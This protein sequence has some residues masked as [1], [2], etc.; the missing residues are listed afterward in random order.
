VDEIV[1]LLTEEQYRGKLVVIFAGYSGQ[2]SELLNKVNPGLKSRVADVIDFPDFT[3]AAAAELAALQLSDKRLQLPDGEDSGY[4]EPWMLQ[5]AAAPLWANGRDVETFVRRV[6]V[7]CATRDT[8]TATTDV[9]DAALQV[10]LQIKGGSSGDPAPVT[11]AHPP[12]ESESPFMTADPLLQAP[13]SFDILKNVQLATL[14]GDDDDDA[15]TD[16]STDF[17]EAL[18]EAVVFLGFDQSDAT[19]E[20]LADMLVAALE[21]GGSFPDIIR[22]RVASKTGAAHEAVDAALRRLARPLLNAVSATVK[23]NTERREQLDE[24]EDEDREEEEGKE[25]K[26]MERLR[27]MGPCPAGFAWFRQGNGWRC[28]GGSHFVYDDDPILK[29]D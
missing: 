13:P 21:P 22:S 16:D 2:M 9:L 17:A 18:E 6:T 5:L 12:P 11:G 15:D 26:I 25:A 4:L 29:F 19:R 28:G 3:P 24:L 23:Y 27:T 7:E 20:K 8:T 10:V 14:D 1:N